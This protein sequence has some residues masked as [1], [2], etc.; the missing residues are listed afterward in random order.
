MCETVFACIYWNGHSENMIS[1]DLIT[2]YFRE[3]VKK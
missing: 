2:L 1:L 3:C